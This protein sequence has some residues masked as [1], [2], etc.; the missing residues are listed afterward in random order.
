[1]RQFFCKGKYISMLKYKTSILGRGQS[2]PDVII[3]GG[4][5]QLIH[6]SF[7][8]PAP[9]QKYYGILKLVESNF[10]LVDGHPAKRE[11]IMTVLEDVTAIYI[12]A[13][14]WTTTLTT[15]WVILLLSNILFQLC[16]C[17]DSNSYFSLESVYLDEATPESYEGYPV[18]TSVEQCLCPPNYQGLSCEECAPGYYRISN[19]PHGGYCVPCECNGHADECDVNTGVCLV[20]QA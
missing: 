11:H 3:E 7:E 17:Y 1:M 2:G 13:T 10:E 12:K 15:S 6:S 16:I 4:G 20:I 14:Y 19:G 18:V 9:L 8:Q 5:L